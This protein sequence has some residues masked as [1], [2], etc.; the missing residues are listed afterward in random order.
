M[1]KIYFRWWFIFVLL[2]WVLYVGMYYYIDTNRGH[3]FDFSE[4]II[5]GLFCSLIVSLGPLLASYLVLPRS[6]Y[7]ENNDSAKP[8]FKV[9]CSSIINIPQG[10]DFRRLQSEIANKWVITHSDDTVNVLKFRTKITFFKS[11]P[12]AARLKLDSDAGNIQLECFPMAS[13]RNDLARKLH[14]EIEKCF[15]SDI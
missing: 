9:T 15:N 1:K 13:H 6:K 11:W 3:D 10:F 4:R 12:V 14:K 5:L 7:V 2:F 8:P